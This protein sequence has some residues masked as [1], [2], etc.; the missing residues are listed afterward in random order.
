MLALNALD[1]IILPLLVAIIL[2]RQLGLSGLA[3]QVSI[4]CARGTVKKLVVITLVLIW[5][6]AG[7]QSAI[8]QTGITVQSSDAHY[9]FGQHIT[10]QL[11][12]SAPT[13]INQIT[14]LFQ[15]QGQMSKTSV[16]I[17][18]EPGLQI[19]IDYVYSLAE[20]E[21]PPFA[22][23]VY[24]WEIRAE[25]GQ[26]HRSP[27]QVLY[28]ADNRYSWQAPARDQYLNTTV[29]IYWVEGDRVF[30][31]NALNTAIVA[32]DQ[33]NRELQTI[34]PGVI[35]IFIYPS[36]QD[37]RSALNLG[38]YDWAGGQARPELETILVGIPN[39]QLAF[40]EMERLI[41]HELAHLLIFEATGRQLNRAP[42]WLNEGLAS[43]YELR[44]DPSRQALV[45]QALAV[46]GLFPLE[47]LC[48]PF[49]LD[50]NAAR[51][52]YAQSAGVVQYI[53][54]RFG[55][56]AVRA[57][58]AAY[59]DSASCESGV[60]R[61]LGMS[62][63][64]LDRA[65]RSTLIREPQGAA[66]QNDGSAWLALWLLTVLASLPLVGIV[67]RSQKAKRE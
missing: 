18:F 6:V 43:V 62:L 60:E 11:Q 9:S 65:W 48:A 22:T 35:R 38:G 27:D 16:P 15:V 30:G 64:G 66:A 42:P 55:S 36:E 14:L 31:Q 47:S 52:A 53:R 58:L 34:I 32:L 10:F 8:A 23:L 21:L 20:H 46:E 49:P 24:W 12:A 28:Y 67:R 5:T 26:Q 33:I 45:E 61:A 1:Q 56:Q 44:P 13:F 41:P 59:A 54:E 2:A 3:E 7:S 25:D 4:L 50:E 40:T 39:D 19:S 57:L 37:L 17:V 51:L 63:N 29:E